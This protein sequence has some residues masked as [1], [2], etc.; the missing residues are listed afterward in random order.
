MYT[1]FAENYENAAAHSILPI[2][3][4]VRNQDQHEIVRY[5]LTFMIPAQLS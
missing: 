4:I 2:S 5:L 3:K 1:L